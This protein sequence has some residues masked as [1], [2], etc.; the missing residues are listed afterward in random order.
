MSARYLL[1]TNI[2][3]ELARREPHAGVLARV[4]ENEARC[5]VAAPTAEEL[6]FGVRRLPASPKREMLER[7]LEGILQRFPVLPYDGRSAIW[8]GQERARLAALGKLAPR[9]DAEIA[10][11]AVTGGLV[12]V[13]R[14]TPDFRAFGGLEVEN[15]FED[16]PP[17]PANAKLIAI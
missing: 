1:D 17:A 7:W 10:A 11:I 15:W 12:L 8:L 4:A 16:V 3:S 13:T 14:N 6:S 5:A 2:V 9:T